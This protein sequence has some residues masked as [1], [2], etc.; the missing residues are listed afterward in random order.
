M[1]M[2]TRDP[3]VHTIRL[4]SQAQN[5]RSIEATI[6]ARESIKVD[7]ESQVFDMCRLKFDRFSKEAKST[8]I[9]LIYDYKP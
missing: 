8:A 1:S 7:D 3:N 4:I 2:S 9:I 6:K 5:N